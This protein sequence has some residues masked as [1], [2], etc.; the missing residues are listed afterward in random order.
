M[1]LS[2][3]ADQDVI[4]TELVAALKRI[5]V[6]GQIVRD[7]QVLISQSMERA[8]QISLQETELK[9][10]QDC[11]SMIFTNLLSKGKFSFDE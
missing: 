1:S 7:Q 8:Q 4:V 9:Q 2:S 11:V 10:A 5:D 6:L 3:P